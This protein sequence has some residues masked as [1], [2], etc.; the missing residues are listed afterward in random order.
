MDIT[1]GTCNRNCILSIPGYR[2]LG[3]VNIC[4]ILYFVIMKKLKLSLFLAIFLLSF[5]KSDITECVATWYDMHGAKTASGVKMH[6]DS[7]TAAYNSVPLHTKLMVTNP[8][9]NKSCI[10][11]VTDRMGNKTPNRIDLSYKAFG[12]IANRSQGK[13][14][15][16]VTKLK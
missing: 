2:W 3:L 15:V 10:V 4:F 13:I 6:R 9:N 7:L 12:E 1:S 5:T 14:N 8:I 11:T 16:I